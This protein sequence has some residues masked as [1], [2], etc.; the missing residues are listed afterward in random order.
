MWCLSDCNCNSKINRVYTDSFLAPD[1]LLYL[2]LF[3][4]TPLTPVIEF[5]KNWSLQKM[6]IRFKKMLI[7]FA[8]KNAN[9]L[10]KSSFYILS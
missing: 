5:I 7:E 10:Q 6:Q 4:L 8:P 1:H 9:L 2:Q 3:D